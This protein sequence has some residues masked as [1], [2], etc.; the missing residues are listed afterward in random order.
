MIALAL[1]LATAAPSVLDAERAFA[2]LAQDKGQWT[3]FR[4]TAAPDAVMFV[5]QPVKAKDRLKD[6]KN[7]PKSVRWQPS[8]AWT[9]CDGSLAVTTGNW[10]SGRA[11]GY[12]TTVWQRQAGGG[13]KWVLNSGDGLKAARPAVARPVVDQ[14]AC[15]GGAMQA[16]PVVA[17]GRPGIAY[18]AEAYSRDATLAYRYKVEPDGA[19]WLRV[20][21]W[22]GQGYALVVEDKVAAAK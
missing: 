6:R 12:F 11:V 7:P 13:W 1:A 2:R 20:S 8:K 19:R 18:P 3:A 14:A 22:D 17:F 15:K 4:A 10:Q 21:R 16:P 5:P 9:S